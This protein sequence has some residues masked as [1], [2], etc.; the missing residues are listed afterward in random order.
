MP[1]GHRRGRLVRGHVDELALTGA[2]AVVERG[3]HRDGTVGRRRQP[4]LVA[5]AGQR[6]IG[7]AVPAR[8]HRAAERHQHEVVGDV[9]GPGPGQAERG[10]RA[11]DEAGCV[12]GQRR[13]VEAAPGGGRRAERVDH[14]VGAAAQPADRLGHRASV[15]DDRPLADVEVPR[16]A[17]SRRDRPRDRRPMD[18]RAG[19]R[20]PAGG[21]TLIDVRAESG[22]QPPAVLDG[23]VDQLDDPDARRA[24]PVPVTEVL[25]RRAGGRSPRR[26]A[27]AARAAR[28]RRPRRCSGGPRRSRPPAWGGV[29]DRSNGTPFERQLAH[30]GVAERHEVVPRRQLRIA[31]EPVGR[32]LHRAGRHPGRLQQVHDLVA[33]APARP[34]LDQLV[35]RRRRVARRPSSVANRW[36]SVHGGVADGRDEGAPLVLGRDTR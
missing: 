6:R 35:E 20:P 17:G 4:G 30:L 9:V 15:D 26:R 18:P 11:A 5:P 14:H 34:R 7:R 22:Q 16:S 33:V 31:L 21:S 2:V 36:S 13:V 1:L 12:L 10:D 32:V 8:R 27:R 28:R 23:L 19:S 29:A 3:E 25:R 24:P